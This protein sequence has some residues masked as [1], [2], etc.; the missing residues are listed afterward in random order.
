MNKSLLIAMG[1]IFAMQSPVFAELMT[2][3]NCQSAGGK[4]KPALLKGP[5][6][7]GDM[8][9]TNMVCSAHMS[10]FKKHQYGVH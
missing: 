4:Y 9:C 5:D 2:E 8:C 10:D 1:V 6:H 3:K 7:H